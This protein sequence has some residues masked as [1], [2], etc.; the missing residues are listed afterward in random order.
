[1]AITYL[2]LSKE[3]RE[4]K[5]RGLYLLHGEEEFVKD[6][7]LAQ[8]CELLLPEDMRSFNE[9]VLESPDAAAIVAACELFPVMAQRKLVL[10]RDYA[11]LS[12]GRAREEAAQREL[13]K[14]LFSDLPPYSALVFVQREAVDAKNKLLKEIAGAGVEVKFD[15]LKERAAADWILASA[16]REGRAMHYEAAEALAYYAG[17]AMGRIHSELEKL[18]S[19]VKEDRSIDTRHVEEICAGDLRFTVFEWLEHVAAGHKDKALLMLRRMQRDKEGGLELI[20][21]AARQ[22]RLIARY[23]GYTSGGM[24]PA[25]AQKALGVPGFVARKVAAQARFFTPEKARAAQQALL[26]AD[27]NVKSGQWRDADLALEVAVQK[28]L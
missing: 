8:L 2:Q 9:F 6:R 20:P 17:P 21:L 25:D 23:H 13:L 4:K 24:R 28:L 3:I 11:L 18:Y 10:V 19:Y 12:K 22:F 1:M 14:G 16:K 26:D 7:M 5:R 27:Y 15:F